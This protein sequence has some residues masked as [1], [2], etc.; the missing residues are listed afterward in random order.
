MEFKSVGEKIRKYRKQ[1]NL[2]QETLAEIVDLSA[3]YI[4]MIERGEKIPSLES[5]VKIA[6][7]L[8]VS[9]DMLL[10]DILKAGY[11][12]KESVLAEK[13]SGLPQKEKNRI[14]DVIETMLNH[15]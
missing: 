15:N 9:A 1:K 14:Y 5:F 3:N 2:R 10:S 8:E 4:G 7:A 6:N 11:V 12:V 13:L